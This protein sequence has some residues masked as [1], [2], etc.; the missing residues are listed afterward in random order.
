MHA[1]KRTV[2]VWKILVMVLL[3][4]VLIFMALLF[5]Q[6]KNVKALAQAVSKNTETI[7][8]DIET[9]RQNTQDALSKYNITVKAPTLA[10]TDAL[11]DGK[12]TVEEVQKDLGWVDT[13]KAS[14]QPENLV[15]ETDAGKT[16]QPGS[17]VQNPE[18]AQ[19]TPEPVVTE[20]P[21]AG[22][23][24]EENKRTADEIVNACLA[25]LYSYEAQ[26]MSQLGI[27]KQA[28]IDEWNALPKEQRTDAKK[29]EI[30]L[31]G[32]DKCYELETQTDAKVQEI[33]AEY[34]T[35][36]KKIGED[37]AIMDQLWSSYCEEKTSTKAY[38]L[39][40]YL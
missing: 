1:K 27:M 10:D 18:T 39:S 28:A 2:S 15:P 6:W 30:G 32:L 19:N 12:K 20:K 17:S 29:R 33:L 16:E 34:R 8:S 22:Q 36:L 3:I 11:L 5:W 23:K 21:D 13:G 14:E 24:P 37:T 35:E 26:L 38:Y 7:A 31:A 9:Q 4:L 25:E 40:K